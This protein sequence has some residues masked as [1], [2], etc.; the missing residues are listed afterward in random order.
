MNLR[1]LLYIFDS[2]V[3]GYNLQEF[4]VHRIQ[5]AIRFVIYFL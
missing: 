4:T 5:Y 3:S 2:D 1:K